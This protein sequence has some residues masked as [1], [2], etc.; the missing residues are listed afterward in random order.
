LISSFNSFSQNVRQ[1]FTVNEGLP[2]SEVYDMI[3]DVNGY[4]WFASDRGISRYN[5]YDFEKFSVSDGLTDYIVLRFFPQDNGEIWCS[6]LNKK[7]FYFHPDDYKFTAYEYNEI[8]DSQASLAI[9]N[10]IYV[11]DDKTVHLGY[12]NR[13]G[14]LSID[15][16]GTILSETN[17]NSIRD[18]VI[19]SITHFQSKGGTKFNYLSD[20]SYHARRP[21]NQA[22][23]VS[24]S[25]K[26]AFYYQSAKLN[27]TVAFIDNQGV[28]IISSKDTFKLITAN[29][30]IGIGVFD[31]IHFWVGYNHGGA[32]LIDKY[33]IIHDSLMVSSTVSD[34]CVDHEGGVWIS[35]LTAGVYYRHNRK[36]KS[37][38]FNREQDKSIRSISCDKFDNI[39]F[40]TASGDVFKQKNAQ[41]HQIY[42]SSKNKPALVHYNR[43]LDKLFFWSDF[44]ILEWQNG[45][46]KKISQETALLSIAKE[47]ETFQLFAGYGGYGWTNEGESNWTT[48]KF[49][50]YDLCKL[51]E[52]LF[53]CTDKGLIQYKDSV[54]NYLSEKNGLLGFRFDD[55]EKIGTTLYLASKGAGVVVYQEDFVTNITVEDGLYSNF[56]NAISRENDSTIWVCSNS[57][58]NRIILHQNNTVSIT[59]VSNVD[60]LINN[61]VMDVTICNGIVWVATRNGISYFST[62]VLDNNKKVTNKFLTINSISINDEVIDMKELLDLSYR[63]NR[64]EINYQAIS[65]KN[66]A[67]LMYRYRIEGLDESWNYT[68]NLSV[69][70]P[71]LPPGDYTFKLGVKGKGESWQESQLSFA[72]NISP[73]YYKT[74][75]FRIV[76][77]LSFLAMVYGFFKVRILTYNRDITRE[78]L[79]HL[80]K[81]FRGDKNYF[82]VKESGTEVKINSSQILY[83]RAEGNY[84]EIHTENG[85]HL[86]RHKIGEFLDLVPDPIEFL[87]VRRSHIV[88]ID[89]IDQKSKKEIYINDEK[90]IVGET[91]LDQLDKITF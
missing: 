61:E 24:F 5:G 39:Y 38:E 44:K 20:S 29:S 65:F 89:K 28:R 75:W 42:T 88:R 15:K 55:V 10:S 18:N 25:S 70:Y 14:F 3:Q 33:G 12:I 71:S 49:R 82:V 68:S 13:I 8:S 64:I 77:T 58:L 30:P 1:H 2:S 4:I 36:I 85:K 57:G 90:I 83:V 7:I 51:N 81:K 16:N 53:F 54:S 23:E 37:V 63:Q 34:I 48:T 22:N 31:S 40:G 78:L 43:A 56:V 76:L 47:H 86:I 9:I 26:N 17:D 6:T 21:L 41:L 67:E 11:D 27:E 52:S 73:P 69:I 84:I 59:G 66:N 72:I 19:N 32:L 62:S 35:T 91:Y 80:L 60:G 45:K 50:T 74:W 79:R 46:S 87:R